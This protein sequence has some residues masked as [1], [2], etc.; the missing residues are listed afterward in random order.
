MEWKSV[1]E[2]IIDFTGRAHKY[3]CTKDMLMYFNSI[4]DDSKQVTA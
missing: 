1:E 4:F 3:A 2:S